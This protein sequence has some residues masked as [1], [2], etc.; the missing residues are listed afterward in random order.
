MPTVIRAMADHH[1][2]QSEMPIFACSSQALIQIICSVIDHQLSQSKMPTF[3][4]ES[5]AK[6]PIIRAA[7]D[8]QLQPMQDARLGMLLPAPNPSYS[9][10]D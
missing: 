6:I 2:N 10:R 4:C 8:H 3:A 7:A 9:N 1:P 5:Q